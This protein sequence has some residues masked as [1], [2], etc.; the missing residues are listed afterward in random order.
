M[1][2]DTVQ[3]PPFPREG[4]TI[5]ETQSSLLGYPRP[6]P[7]AHSSPNIRGYPDGAMPLQID[8]DTAVSATTPEGEIVH[9]QYPRNRRVREGEGADTRKQGIPADVH[10]EMMK[11]SRPCSHSAE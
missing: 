6:H 7:P 8:E 10:A 1:P 4:G 5:S 2:L 9:A 11:E 3:T